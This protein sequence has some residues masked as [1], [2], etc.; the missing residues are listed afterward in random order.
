[1][2]PKIAEREANMRFKSSI[3]LGVLGTAVGLGTF[4]V[5]L[6][7]DVS[8]VPAARAAPVG[9]AAALLAPRKERA[10]EFQN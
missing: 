2:E 3:G 8:A 10:I 9:A 1:M 6:Q 7:L 5:V 4:I